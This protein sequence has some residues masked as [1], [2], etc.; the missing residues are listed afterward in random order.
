M[1]K[2]LIRGLFF[3][4]VGFAQMGCSTVG[5]GLANHPGDCA[6][7][8][9]WADCL[10]GTAGYANGGGRVHREEAQKQK[11]EAAAP[12]QAV[13]EQCKSDFQNPALDVLRN[14]VELVRVGA[15][16]APPFEIATNDNFPTQSEREEIAVWAKARDECIKREAT[17]PLGSP[18]ATQLQI[19]VAQ[20]DRSISDEVA[21]K[22]GQLIIALYQ[23]KMTYGEF[24]QKRYEISRDGA[25]TQNQFRQSILLADQDKQLQA[26]QLAQQQYQNNLAAWS[27]YTQSVAARQPQSVRINCTTTKIG[28]TATTNCY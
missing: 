9:P 18:N 1:L 27:A 2:I 8:I 13:L 19:A 15:T 12:M 10:P 23:Q 17:V 11:E 6:L 4:G 16:I 20:R 7:G 22:V 3:L 26:Q 5:P 24:A 25:A 21:G 28:N 14:K